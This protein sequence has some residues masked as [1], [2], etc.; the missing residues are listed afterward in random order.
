[1]WYFATVDSPCI[2]SRIVCFT[3]SAVSH[4][5]SVRLDFLSA[6]DWAESLSAFPANVSNAVSSSSSLKG[7]AVAFA[8]DFAL[9]FVAFFGAIVHNGGKTG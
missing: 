5:L 1:V 8:F 2:A 6:A 3:D 9:A 4:F 7:T